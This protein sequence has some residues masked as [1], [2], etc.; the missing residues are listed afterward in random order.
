MFGVLNIIG[1]P[2]VTAFTARDLTRLRTRPYAGAEVVALKLL[3]GEKPDAWII[4]PLARY[5]SGS[6]SSSGARSMESISTI[7]T[8]L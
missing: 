4:R 2:L 1:L 8:S 7:A 3:A 6:G 5:S